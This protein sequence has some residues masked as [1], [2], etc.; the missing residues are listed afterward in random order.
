MYQQPAWGHGAHGYIHAQQGPCAY[1]QQGYVQAAQFQQVDP[2]QPRPSM[3]LR[4]ISLEYSYHELSASTNNWHVSRRLGSG[5]YGAVYKGELEDGSEVAIKAIDLGALG[6]AGTSPEMSGF[7]EEVQMLSKFRHPNLVTLLG[8]GKH[9]LS[10]YLVYELLAGGDCFQRLQKSKKPGSLTPFHWFERLSVLLDASTGLS[11]MH[12]SKP[13]AFHRDI[14]SANILLDRHGTAKMADFGLSCTS[15]Q[16]NSLH[17]TVRTVSGTPGYACPVYS[18]TGRVTEGSEVYSFGMLMLELLTGLA[19]AT[20]DPSR[21][22]GIAYQVNDAIQQQSPGAA[23]RCLRSLDQGANW[24]SQLAREITELALRG[25]ISQ[26]EGRPRFVEIVRTLRKLTEQFPRP[27]PNLPATYNQ[28][29]PQIPQHLITGGSGGSSQAAAPAAGAVSHAGSALPPAAAAAARRPSA[30]AAAALPAPHGNPVAQAA[31]GQAGQLAVAGQGAYVRPQSSHSENFPSG[32]N[33]AAAVMQAAGGSQTAQPAVGGAS[34]ASPLVVASPY[35]KNTACFFLQLVYAHGLDVSSLPEDCRQLPISPSPGSNSENNNSSSILLQVG[36]SFQTK[37]FELWVPDEQL[38]GCIS[39]TAFEVSCGSKGENAQL[40]VR[41]S[42]TV[43]V[44][45]NVAPRDIAVS[46]RPGSEVG[47]SHG[48]TPDF[49]LLLRFCPAGQ[50][51]QENI[52]H[53]PKPPSR[54]VAASEELGSSPSSPSK[55]PASSSSSPSKNPASMTSSP[56]RAPMAKPLEAAAYPNGMPSNWTLSCVHVEGLT[57][58]QVAELPKDAKDIELASGQ[59]LLGRLHQKQLENILKLAQIPTHLSFISRSHVQ[60]ED[61]CE[62]GV[63]ITNVSSNPLYL[64]NELLSH[65]E[66]RLMKQGQL[67]NFARSEPGAGQSSSHTHFL[68]FQLQPTRMIASRDASKA[69]SN[70]KSQADAIAKADAEAAAKAREELDAKAKADAEAKKRTEA[71]AAAEIRAGVEAKA[72]ADAKAKV[73]AEAEL[74]AK[75]RAEVE[76]KVRAEADARAV[77]EAEAK[78]KAEAEAAAKAA[79]IRAEL[80]AQV[81]AEAATRALAEAEAKAKGEAEAKANAR[82]KQNASPERSDGHTASPPN[83][84]VSP[85]KRQVVRDSSSSPSRVKPVPASWGAQ[86]GRI[87][88]ASAAVF[89][90][91][92]SGEGVLDVP[93]EDRRIRYELCKASP[94]VVG[95]KHQP[96]LHRRAVSSESLQYMSRDHFQIFVDNGEIKLTAMTSNP[97]WRDRDGNGAVELAKGDTVSLASGDRIALSTGNDNSSPAFAIRNLCWHFRLEG[98]NSSQNSCTPA[99]VRDSR[100]GSFGHHTPPSPGGRGPRLSGGPPPWA[101]AGSTSAAPVPADGMVARE[102]LLGDGGAPLPKAKSKSRP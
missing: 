33:A 90:L 92:L 13:K 87:G 27:T 25:V 18:R 94:L 55:V 76:A 101:T 57:A 44:D 48:T 43:S 53:Q 56:T 59:S 9:N 97:I 6:A 93:A 14:K 26:D 85:P 82:A 22:G 71:E 74:A 51:V 98:S 38:R 62:A 60:A 37:A 91:E 70:L 29:V 7:E 83:R 32:R 28:Q 8:W 100:T 68:S 99:K 77:L 5:S 39:R 45:G 66:S 15:S 88:D 20:A 61:Q 102:R 73:K 81:R 1:H 86:P 78:V 10:R 69:A 40:F 72:R 89:I 16:A 80:E 42:G 34:P 17:V 35:S 24:P 54:P 12:N 67:L 84:Q 30:E 64:E 31:S 11:H 2:R 36:R 65:S 58:T 63:L 47:F 21:P 46:L 79:K 19:P 52:A 75:I 23:E 50:D 49:F 96:E 3:Q 4:E 41:G 95:R